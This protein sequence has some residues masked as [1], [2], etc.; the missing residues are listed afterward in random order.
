MN[1][2]PQYLFF[3]GHYALYFMLFHRL[4]APLLFFLLPSSL[5]F[6]TPVDILRM[7]AYAC[8]HFVGCTPIR[9]SS[10]AS[11]CTG[12]L[13]IQFVVLFFCSSYIHSFIRSLAH[14]LLH[15]SY[16][17]IPTRSFIHDYTMIITAIDFSSVL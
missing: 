5:S 14:F 16:Y 6:Y 17:F 12:N 11:L 4:A 13:T 3:L 7:C 2:A 9:R 10:F 15:H 1:P 8:L